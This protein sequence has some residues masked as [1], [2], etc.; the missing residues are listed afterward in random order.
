MSN[1]I[2]SIE[3][4]VSDFCADQGL[5][6]EAGRGLIGFSGGPDSTALLLI[7]S[8]L[9]FECRAVHINHGLRSEASA[10][11]AWCAEFCDRIGVSFKSYCRPINELRQP[12]ESVE[13]AGRRERLTLLRELADGAG[14]PLALGH[15]LDDAVET[16]FMRMMRGANASGLTGLRAKRNINGL[17]IV[18]PLLCL[19]RDDILSYLTARAVDNF[20]RDRSNDSD[21]HLRNRVRKRLLPVLDDLGGRQGAYETLALL[22]EDAR[23]L[24]N[25]AR[26]DDGLTV[27]Q[28]S[29]TPTC[30]WPRLLRYLCIEQHDCDLVLRRTAIERLQDEVGAGW[31]HGQR[32]DI[33]D[34]W[35]LINNRSQVVFLAAKAPPTPPS[36]D[37]HWQTDQEISIPAFGVV[38]KAE[39]TEIERGMPLDADGCQHFALGTLPTVLTLRGR[40]PGDRIQT[41]SGSRRVKKLIGNAKLSL[42]EKQQLLIICDGDTILWIPG[43]RRAAHGF[44]PDLPAKAIKITVRPSSPDCT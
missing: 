32:I 39:A 12:G 7:L 8:A 43:V 21:D 2:Q 14:E 40:F 10:D 16:F 28:L 19:N 26:A 22:E 36:I 4:R 27:A 44:L 13:M 11:E 41:P 20:R 18:R 5:L 9:G 33:G 37:W 38:L 23:C 15:H 17:T 29:D 1:P 6:P 34:G 42:A 3:D 25:S 24:E 31:D 35:E 30:L